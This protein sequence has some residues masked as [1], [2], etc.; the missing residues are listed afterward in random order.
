MD[1]MSF[2][3]KTSKSKLH[4]IYV[5]VGDEDFLKRRVLSK[6][7]RLIIEDADPSFAS[8][9]YAGDKVEFATVRGELETL[10]F[11]SKH[12]LLVLDQADP[13]VTKY[14]ASLETYAENPSATGVLV[15]DVKT[16]LATTKLA[17][18]VPDSATMVCK[19][20]SVYK[21]PAWCVDWTRE[22]YCKTLPIN[23]A[24]LLVSLVG[25]HMGLLDSE[26]EKLSN[27]VGE[28]GI[29][30]SAS[31]DLLVGRSRAANVFKIM[32]AVGE[33]NAKNALLILSELFDQGEAPLAILGALGAQLRRLGVASS[34]HKAGI[35]LED[36]MDRAGIAKWP[37]ARES[38]RNQMKH[39]GWN[40]LDKLLDWLLEVDQG[41]KGGNPLPESFLLERLIV[42]LARPRS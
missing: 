29:I 35:Q 30:D 34:L 7:Q 3:G 38:T 31:V 18:K 21:L 25:A 4:P 40:R 1:A 26:L 10:P 33:G 8:A 12:R 36:A 28:K 42:R 24:E 32:D 19:A 22:R 16:W 6:L 27:Y 17:K 13:F 2:L 37:Q 41:M 9:N 11:L 39:L 23:A 20:P 14:R 5:L 15:L